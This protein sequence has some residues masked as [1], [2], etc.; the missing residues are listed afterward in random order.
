MALYNLFEVMDH[1]MEIINDGY[2]Y[3][4]ISEI[5][6]DDDDPASLSFSV[7]DPDND[8]L[9]IDYESI[10][11]LPDDYDLSRCSITSDKVCYGLTL[12]ELATVHHALNNALEYFKECSSDK[13]YSKEV[14][15]DIKASSVRCRN[16]Q[17]KTLKFLNKFK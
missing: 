10:D 4:D 1:I 2:I 17:A 14:L 7:P 6:R 11:A 16:L 3:A 9:A 15:N 8:F 12:E 5:P 13:S